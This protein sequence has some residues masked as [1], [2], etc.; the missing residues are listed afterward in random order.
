MQ[1][2]DWEFNLPKRH[3]SL[4]CNLWSIMQE[5]LLSTDGRSSLNF[6]SLLNLD[7][8]PWPRKERSW[9]SSV[10]G[11][12]V[13]T[14]LNGGRIWRTNT[15][16][17]IS[18]KELLEGEFLRIRGTYQPF[19]IPPTFLGFAPIYFWSKVWNEQNAFLLGSLSCLAG[20]TGQ[21]CSMVKGL[22]RTSRR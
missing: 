18:W 22:H 5:C 6:R 16:Q 10:A 14:L 1:T 19:L 15:L 20:Y 9:V 2:A 17:R 4:F 7:N 12:G 13:E 3:P 21:D 11:L 8:P